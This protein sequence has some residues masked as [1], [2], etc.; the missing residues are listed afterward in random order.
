MSRNKEL[1][2]IKTAR[3]EAAIN[4]GA[5]SGFFPL[6]KRVIPSEKIRSKFAVCQ[7]PETG[8]IRVIGDYR[9]G[10]GNVID[11]TFY[12]PYSCP[13]PFAAYL[14]PPDLKIGEL[15]ILEDLIE[16]FVGSSWNQGAMYRLESCE[17]IWDGKDFDIL[18]DPDGPRLCSIVG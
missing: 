11:F 12:Y 16:E 18:C 17:A 2:V 5:Q 4:E 1:R 8:F 6:I 10:G 14:I 3:D 15:V 7:D 13:S 9:E